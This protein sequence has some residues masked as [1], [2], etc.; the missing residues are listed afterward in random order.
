MFLFNHFLR[1]FSSAVAVCVDYMRLN[2]SV[3][4]ASSILAG[5]IILSVKMKWNHSSQIKKFLVLT[6]SS[7]LIKLF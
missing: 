3:L 5:R 7:S 4:V 2:T 6:V 1:V